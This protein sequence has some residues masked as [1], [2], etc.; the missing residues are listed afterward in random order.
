MH[1][2]T[3]DEMQQAAE[4][5]LARSTGVVAPRVARAMIEEI[6]RAKERETWQARAQRCRTNNRSRDLPA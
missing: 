1:R 3:L 5:K 2:A 4:D 6:R